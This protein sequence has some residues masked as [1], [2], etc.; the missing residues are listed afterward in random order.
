MLIALFLHADFANIPDGR[1]LWL[2]FYKYG[3][4]LATW[5]FVIIAILYITATSNAVNLTDGMDG[6]AAGCLGMV[7]LVLVVLCYVAS[8]K[9]GG[10]G[11]ANKG[12]LEKNDRLG[13]CRI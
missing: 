3:L 13:A 11:Q 1:R 8:E 5:V 4:P 10:K 12:S 6:L 7:S 2:P 9:M